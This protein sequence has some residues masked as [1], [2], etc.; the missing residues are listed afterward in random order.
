MTRAGKIAEPKKQNKIM[1]SCLIRRHE[2]CI[3]RSI[4]M[5]EHTHKYT[6]T[7]I[8][9]YTTHLNSESGCNACIIKRIRA[10]TKGKDYN[11]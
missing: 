8:T 9:S 3:L 5:H 6:N 1:L 4:H 7:P 2:T 11:I 10:K